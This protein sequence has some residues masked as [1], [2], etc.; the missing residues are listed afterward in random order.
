MGI[1]YDMLREED[2][3]MGNT[4]FDQGAVVGPD[5]EY[6][7][8]LNDIAKAVEDLNDERADESEQK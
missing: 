7:V 4:G 5:D 3:L 1:Y 6:T 8:Q 2:E